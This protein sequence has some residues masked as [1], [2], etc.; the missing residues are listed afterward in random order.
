MTKPDDSSLEAEDLRVVEKRARHLLDRAGAWDR[1]PVP[2]EDILAA[3]NVRLA[4]TSVF[5]PI[6][7]LEY[8]KGKAANTGRRIKSAIAKVLGIY[9]A[10]RALFISTK[11]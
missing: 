2:I 4:P 3:A 11:R 10:A 1:F 7:I 6:A 8:L 9:D 5:D